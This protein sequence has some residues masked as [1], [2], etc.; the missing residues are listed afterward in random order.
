MTSSQAFSRRR[1]IG[2]GAGALTIGAV[3]GLSACTGSTPPL[4]PAQG[5]GGANSV[6]ESPMLAEQVK[7]GKLPKLAERLPTKPMVQELWS[8]PGQYGGTLHVAEDDA[9]QAQ[10]VTSYASYGLLEWNLRGTDGVPSLAESFE[11]NSDNSEYRIKL[12]QGL[13]WSDGKPLTTDDVLFA[14]K[15]VHLNKTLNPTPPVWLRNPDLT[16]PKISVDG[17]AIVVKFK[18]PFSLFRKYLY[19][20]FQSHQ[21]IKP[22][23]YLQ[24]FHPDF[25]SQKKL[26]AAAK[27]AGFD[28]WDQL[29]GAKDDPWL[30][31]DRPT[32]AAFVM[33]KAASGNSRTASYVRNP[34]YFKTDPD[35]RQLPYIDKMNAQILSDDTL[36]LRAAN[37][38]L[39]LQATEL[40]FTSTG[41]LQKSAESKGFRVMRWQARSS[42]INLFLNLSHKDPATRKL[43][44]NIDFRAALSHAI[45]RDELNSQLLGGIGTY[46]QFTP[47]PPDAYA[48]DGAGRRFLEYDVATANKLLDGL[49]LTKRNSSGIRLRSDGK[50]LEFVVIFVEAA[51]IVKL[52]DALNFVANTWKE[53]GVKLTLKPVDNT[54]YYEILPSNS[55]D[56][57]QY[58][59]HSV[60]WDMEPIWFVPQNNS[61][62]AAPAYGDWCSTNGKVGMEP[63]DDIKNLWKLWGEL[64]GAPTDEA[65]IE[66]GRKIT[67]QWDEQVYVIGLIGIPFR[68]AIANVK[69]QN[70]RDDKEVPSVYFHGF[71]GVTKPDQQWFKD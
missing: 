57:I 43:F 22:K 37:G 27:K 7:A 38:E 45:N 23:H 65:R 2:Y 52:S 53:I 10:V 26:E 18:G 15:D 35:G 36:N 63:T 60:D 68:P 69:L 3:S 58:T 16:D 47:E 46:R 59:G 13:K 31:A 44:A 19:M 8:G 56:I 50:P 11:A 4:P 12:R 41:L 71:E 61:F 62:R 29:F 30:N 49:G 14:F 67:K 1:L 40:A 21:A 32:A 17:D 6:R 66:A 9:L 48:I 64:V 5:G 39:D 20:P 42:N 54:L 24:A 28:T 70:V 51:A 25:T 55:Y 34:Y 33:Q